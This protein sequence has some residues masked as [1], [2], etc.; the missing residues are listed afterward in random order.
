MA[1]TRF[2][3]PGHARC[4]CLFLH[5]CGFPLKWLYVELSAF[6]TTGVNWECFP[7]TCFLRNISNP[8]M[9]ISWTRFQVRAVQS[10]LDDLE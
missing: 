9:R 7:D 1:L 10:E 6:N 8:T 3:L 2:V 5:D 4:S